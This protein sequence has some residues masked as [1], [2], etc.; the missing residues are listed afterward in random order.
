MLEKNLPQLEL[1]FTKIN[2]TLRAAILLVVLFFNF[3]LFAQNV[4]F[5]GIVYDSET[6]EPIVSAAIQILGLERY[7]ISSLDGEFVFKNIPRKEMTLKITHLAYKEKLFN[8]SSAVDSCTNRLFFLTPKVITISTVTVTEHN[9]QSKFDDLRELSDVIKGKELQKDLGITLASTLKNEAG[10]AMRSMGPAPSRPVIRGLG[11]DRVLM[12]EDGNKTTDLSSSSPD[13][14]VTIEPFTVD[15]IEVIRGPKVLE[16]TST[17]LGGIVNVIRKEIPEEIHDQLTGTI[18]AYGE[19]VNNGYLGSAVLEVPFNP[20]TFRGEFSLRKADDISTPDGVLKN[21]YSDNMSYSFGGSYI[22]DFGFLGGSFRGYELN[23]GVPGG[24]LGAHPYGVDITMKRYQWNAKSRINIHGKYLQHIETQVSRVYYRHKEFEK[25]GAIG[26]EFEITNY[27]GHVNFDHKN[28]LFPSNGNLG[29]SFEARD[30]V[31]G[32]FVFTPP[33]KSL[34]LAA[35][36]YETTTLD[37]LNFEFSG[38][39][40]YDR[41][42]PKY[43]KPDALIGNM[44]ERTFSTYSLSFSSLYSVSEHVHIGINISKSSRVPTIEELFSE[45]PHL[46]AYS[47]EIGNPDLEN[48]CGL[49]TELFI[50][51]KFNNLYFNFNIFRNDLSYY[52]MPRN[53]G[54]TDWSTFLPIYAS[55]GTKALFYGSEG[56]VEWKFTN[57]FALETSISFTNGSF[58]ETGKPLPQIPP[59]KGIVG[60]NYSN[61][62]FSFG[63]NAEWAAAQNRVDEFEEPTRGYF[64]LNSFMQYSFSQINL[65]HTFSISFDNM[66]NAVYRNHLSRVKSILPEAGRNL[67]L[68]YKLYFY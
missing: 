34:N 1:M 42:T 8:V 16:Q 49:G 23:Y 2:Q 40:N 28:V 3:S 54:K 52:I 63:I 5:H 37:N 45:G 58:T 53:T 13:H 9:S 67:R 50:Y 14:A 26:S 22:N 11:G 21:S 59:L 56:Q 32:G 7:E 46:A 41:I 19:T 27:L 33:S 61:D 12:S 43:N 20:I 6:N 47:Y 65:L 39:L 36:L 57:N 66:L 44:K 29:V 35:Y 17:T 64:V 30:F 15:R 48:E 10:I 38:R 31:V 4:D 25:N 51:H 55:S 24:F 62:I 68:T 60:I 18:G